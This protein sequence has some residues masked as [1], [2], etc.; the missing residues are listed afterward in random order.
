MVVTEREHEVLLFEQHEHAK[1]CGELAEAWCEEYFIGKRKRK[2]VIYAI[3]EHDNGWIELDESPLINRERKI[4]FSFIDYPLTPKIK[5]YKKGID[6]I[7]KK[8]RYAALI[9]SLHYASF[10]ERY[11]NGRGED[12]LSLERDRQKKLKEKLHIHKLEE[13]ELLFHYYLLQFCDNLSLYLCMNEPGVDKKNE[14]IWFRKG[15]SQRFAF[16]NK[17]RI[18]AHWLD[19][20]TVSLTDFPFSKELTVSL[21]YKCIQK[22]QMSN[23]Q[24]E[25]KHQKSR[26]RKITIVGCK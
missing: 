1:V 3:Y 22:S 4:P 10:F 17:K 16:N 15:F 7:E 14:L 23:L 19:K 6:I 18:V 8:D 20:N 12:F 5:A 26:Q 2:S 11:T 9:C 25:Y 21:K 24:V 13:E